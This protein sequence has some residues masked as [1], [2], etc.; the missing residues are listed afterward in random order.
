MFELDRTIPES[1]ANLISQADYDKILDISLEFFAQSDL[2]VTRVQNGLIFLAMDETDRELQAGLDNLVKTLAKTLPSEWQRV[3]EGHFARLT[4]LKEQEK[5]YNFFFKDFEY[6]QQYLRV[7]IK[8]AE[9]MPA[10]LASELVKKIDFPETHTL[11][12]FDFDEQ[13]RFLTQKDI[14]EWGVHPDEL[15]EIARHHIKSENIE[16]EEMV[17]NEEYSIYA[18]FSGDFAASYLLD[19]EDNAEFCIGEYGTLLA[20]PAKGAAFAHP[21]HDGE[22]LKVIETINPLVLQFYD[23]EPGS[24]NAHYYWYFQGMW[25]I[26]P[27]EPNSDGMS[28]IKLPK[29][30]EKMLYGD[31]N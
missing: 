8:D 4:K 26:F 24:I 6:A 23:H 20:I 17:W 7:L 30:L 2:Q 10:N 27:I 12:V 22:V 3:I 15:F 25:D 9:A 18:F 16:I 14:E 19:I 5:A 28:T 29:N 13:F 1:Y 31:K 11:L 21:I